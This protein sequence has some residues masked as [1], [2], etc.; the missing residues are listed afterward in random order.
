MAQLTY[1]ESMLRAVRAALQEAITSGAKSATVSAG[2]GSESYTRHSLAELQE[3]ER[4]FAQRVNA[5]AATKKRVAP[6]FG[7]CV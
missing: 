1:S 6:D 7:R 4:Q 2:G 3:M 5:E